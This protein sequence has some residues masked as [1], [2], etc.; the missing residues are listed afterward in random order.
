[1]AR[2]ALVEWA[3]V[4]ALATAGCSQGRTLVVQ[5][6]TDLAP[7]VEFDQASV[8]APERHSRRVSLDDEFSRPMHLAE[9]T[10]LAEGSNVIVDVELSSGSRHVVSRRVQTRV[11]GD[12]IVNVIITRN[13]VEI[14]CPMPSAP[15]ATEC[16]DGVCVPPDCEA[17]GCASSEC[18]RDADCTSSVAC[19]VPRC[20]FGTCLDTPDNSACLP[21][22]ACIPDLGCIWAAPPD[23]D[24]A[25]A[26]PDAGSPDAVALPPPDDA[27]TPVPDAYVGPS[28]TLS[29]LPR[30]GASWSNIPVTGS[31]PT[32]RVEA[33]FAP[34]GGRELFVLTHTELFVFDLGTRTFTER[35]PRDPAFPE[36]A[37]ITIEGAGGVD[38]RVFVNAHDT[39]I[40]E[41]APTTRTGTL[42]QFVRYEDL[43][44]DWR[45]PLAPP[46]HQLYAS[47]Y[48]T[49]NTDGWAHADAMM[50]CG[51]TVPNHGVYLTTSGFAP[52]QLVV[53][54][55]DASCGQ[56]VA[57]AP[58]GT[59]SY[60]AF[61]LP[62][63]PLPFD[64]VAAEYA[65]G[66]WAF[67]TP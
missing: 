41:F 14:A 27:F 59:A 43:G 45:G 38:T 62:G 66:L 48:L 22:E 56:F 28:F 29:F 37:G 4:V 51:A 30:G 39:W 15:D 64:I 54:V 10:G 25:L 1:M 21:G 34:P 60:T 18:T 11:Q 52:P 23:A 31:F 44:A 63:A 24:A 57:R 55:Y 65:E 7:G 58:Y 20:V 50:L 17:D 46:W 5:L 42:T 16:R 3:L 9:I 32:D 61:T 67:T 35:R 12:Q 47:F 8:R 49:D 36:L 6:Q 19:V 53:S 26:S 40:Y 13:C 33:A 2:L